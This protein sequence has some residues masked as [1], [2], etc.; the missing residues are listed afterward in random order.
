MPF[1]AS[2]RTSNIVNSEQSLAVKSRAKITEM[3][4]E[5][6]KRFANGEISEQIYLAPQDK[7]QKRPSQLP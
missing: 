5:L 4:D 1:L 3:L 7:W 2:P 6:D